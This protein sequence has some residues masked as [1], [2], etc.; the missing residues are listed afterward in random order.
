V[1]FSGREGCGK[2]TAALVILVLGSCGGKSAALVLV[3]GEIAL[4][5]P[6]VVDC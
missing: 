4:A 3:F 1:S 2:P 5:L 6:A